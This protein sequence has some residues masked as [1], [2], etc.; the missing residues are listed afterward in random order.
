MSFFSRSPSSAS[1]NLSAADFEAR[2]Q[3]DDPILDVRTP[4]EFDTGHL[5]GAENVNLQAPDF[6]AQIEALSEQGVIARDRPVYLY[7]RSGNRSGMAARMLREMGFSD[8]Y[9]IGGY[10]TLKANGTAVSE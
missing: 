10:A 9:N 6:Q 5:K 8:A 2:R 7:C 3:P 1:L 4:R